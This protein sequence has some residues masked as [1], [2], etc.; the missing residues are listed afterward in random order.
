MTLSSYFY[1]LNL[2]VVADKA[3]LESKISKK[4]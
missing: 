1:E 3:A 2:S 4:Y